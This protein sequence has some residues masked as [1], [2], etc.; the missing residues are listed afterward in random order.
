MEAIFRNCFIAGMINYSI[1][2]PQITNVKSCPSPAIVLA[3]RASARPANVALIQLNSPQKRGLHGNDRAWWSDVR[4]S[5]LSVAKE[6]CQRAPRA[7]T[8]PPYCVRRPSSPETT[9]TDL[10]RAMRAPSHPFP[11]NRGPQPVT[12]RAL[13]ANPAIGRPQ[14]RLDL[15]REIVEDEI[16]APGTYEKHQMMFTGIDDDFAQ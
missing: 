6:L 13:H 14:P 9:Y 4:I 12:A 10:C 7:A 16:A 1:T 2:K 5:P 8:G 15:W 3:G 11:S